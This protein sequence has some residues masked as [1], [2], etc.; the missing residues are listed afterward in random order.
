MGVSLRGGEKEREREREKEREKERERKREREKESKKAR[1]QA[2]KQARKKENA[3]LFN[4]LARCYVIYI[5]VL[6][7][8]YSILFCNPD[9]KLRIYQDDKT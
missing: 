8:N 5:F 6:M 3:D 4:H 7:N 2:S 1:K 9:L